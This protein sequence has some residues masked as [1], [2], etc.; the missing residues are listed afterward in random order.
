M[1]LEVTRMKPRKSYEYVVEQIESAICDGALAPGER[2]PSEM[3]LKEMFD[4]SRGTVR[5]ALRV[6][7]QKGLVT[8]RT[9]VKGGADQRHL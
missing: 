2:L 6:L 9:G 5:E 1:V 8:V 3:K 7:E 4:T